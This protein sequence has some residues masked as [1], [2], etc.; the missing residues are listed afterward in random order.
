MVL[1]VAIAALLNPDFARVSIRK[2]FLTICR[3]SINCSFDLSPWVGY[4]AV[5]VHGHGDVDRTASYLYHISFMGGSNFLQE[6]KIAFL[7]ME[8]GS[9]CVFLF[10]YVG[11]E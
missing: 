10:A 8:E 11:T 3:Q 6:E 4:S 9:Y 5:E 7:S 1:I 2:Q